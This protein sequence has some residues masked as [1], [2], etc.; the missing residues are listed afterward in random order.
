ME[1]NSIRNQ[2]VFVTLSAVLEL[3]KEYQR[4]LALMAYQRNRSE[5]DPLLAERIRAYS[6]V[7]NT[8]DLPIEVK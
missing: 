8:L 1:K 3:Q 6:S 2:K 4:L 5:S 7:I